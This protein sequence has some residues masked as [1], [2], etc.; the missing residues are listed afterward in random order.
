MTLLYLPIS[1]GRDNL[2][3]LYAGVWKGA[4]RRP[5]NCSHVGLVMPEW[6]SGGASVNRRYALASQSKGAFCGKFAPSKAH[7]RT[8]SVGVAAYEGVTAK[9]SEGSS[10]A[11]SIK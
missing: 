11:I 5:N 3:C 7:N 1:D 4:D 8:A 9:E 6:N 2:S 10:S